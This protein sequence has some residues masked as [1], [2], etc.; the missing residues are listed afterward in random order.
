MQSFLAKCAALGIVAGGF[1]LTGDLGRLADRGRRLLDARTVPSEMA[2]EPAVEAAS[3][4]PSV[5][6]ASPAALPEATSPLEV[7]Q[8]AVAPAAN[9]DTPTASA[10]EP[11]R[12]MPRQ[13][14]ADAPVGR[15]VS[16]PA[17]PASSPDS[18]D[19]RQVTAGSRLLIWIR[20]PGASARSVDLVALDIIDPM[21]GEALEN[22]H[23]ALTLGTAGTVGTHA[24]EATAI[25]VSPR[26]VVITRN[27]A[28]CITKGSTLRVAPLHGV[29]GLGPEEHVGTIL[30]FSVPDR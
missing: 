14:R 1:T 20:R 27:A 2:A 17:P 10:S 24:T 13:A 12:S 18:I 21:S 7:T 23:A 15:A 5:P 4:L 3:A 30:A 26:R 22:R 25:H 6:T 29:N 8:A 19:L 11:T 28:S 16:V 9:P